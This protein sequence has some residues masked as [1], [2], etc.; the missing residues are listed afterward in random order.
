M[1]CRRVAGVQSTSVCD[2][3]SLSKED[4]DLVLDEFP[5]M[6]TIMES[7][8]RERLQLIQM[9]SN[10]PQTNLTPML[11]VELESSPRQGRYVPSLNIIQ[12]SSSAINPGDM[13]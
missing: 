6:R 5:D 7:V 4:F 12:S 1:K 3:Y 9:P 10:S 11:P 2:L 13:V 8:A